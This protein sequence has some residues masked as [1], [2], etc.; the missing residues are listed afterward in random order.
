M[1]VKFLLNINICWRLNFP[2]IFNFCWILNSRWILNF[3]WILKFCWILNFRWILNFCWILNFRWILNFCWILNFRWMFCFWWILNFRW[4]SNFCWNV[5]M[6]Y[7]SKNFH[8]MLL[9]FY[10]E[11]CYIWLAIVVFT[12]IFLFLHSRKTF[13][14]NWNFLLMEFRWLNNFLFLKNWIVTFSLCLSSASFAI[15]VKCFVL[16]YHFIDSAIIDFWCFVRGYYYSSIA[17]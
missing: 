9:F 6:K 17:V 7:Y 5:E 15:K 8:W 16:W 13:W 11:F 3:L 12:E 14:F 1:N 2:W 4:M 10:I